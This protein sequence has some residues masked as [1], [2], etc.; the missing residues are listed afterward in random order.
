MATASCNRIHTKEAASGWQRW[1]PGVL[2]A[3]T[4]PQQRPDSPEVVKR[5]AHSTGFEEGKRAGF[6][7]G[8]AEGQA[9]AQAEAAQLSQVAKSAELALRSLGDVLAAK[10]VALAFAIAQKILLHEI[11]TRPESMIEVVR[12][13]LELLPE[14]AERVRIAVN[15][16]DVELVRRALMEAVD[17]PDSTVVGSDD[18]QR[19]GCRISSPCGDIDA[20]LETRIG[21]VIETLGLNQ[22]SPDEH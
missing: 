10:T 4:A 13:A 14:G 18:V 3:A 12:A 7:A 22:D 11:E 8:Y 1:H 17:T 16:A 2:D 20:T 6:Q 19:G 21:R 9:R 15:T 5:R